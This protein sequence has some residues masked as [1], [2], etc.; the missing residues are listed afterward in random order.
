MNYLR[1]VEH[2]LGIKS[3]VV[4]NAVEGEMKY[5][6]IS[7]LIEYKDYKYNLNLNGTLTT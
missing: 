5:Y 4:E 7:I 1:K 3:L 2:I 6:K